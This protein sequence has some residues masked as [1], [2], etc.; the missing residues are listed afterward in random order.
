MCDSA[1]I[2]LPCRPESAS[3]ARSFIR[4]WFLHNA[5]S[6]G[7]HFDRLVLVASEL[8][9]NAGA[10]CVDPITVELSLCDGG[11]EVSIGDDS[12]NFPVLDGRATIESTS[13]RGLSIVE[14][15]SDD[16][17]VRGSP[18]GKAVWA[19]VGEVAPGPACT[20]GARTS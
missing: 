5:V 1:L 3:A 14:A 17:G 2:R 9:A 20:R 7:E 8:V 11:A 13:G 12:P 18:N 6:D 10:V 19:L 16:W 15:L 4:D